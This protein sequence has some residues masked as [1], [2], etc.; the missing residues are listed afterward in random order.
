MLGFAS[1]EKFHNISCNF[2]FYSAAKDGRVEILKECVKKDANGR[3]EN[4]M[5]P[6]LWAAFEGHLEALRLLVGKGGD[7]DRA[8]IFGNTALHLAAARG[9]YSCVDFLVKFG[10]NLYSLDV[11]NHTAK[12]LGAIHNRDDILRYLDAATAHLEN[13]EK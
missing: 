5:T 11:D 8:D 12:E 4:G 2:L 1:C 9:H 13:T 3:D 10:C 7:P 6:V